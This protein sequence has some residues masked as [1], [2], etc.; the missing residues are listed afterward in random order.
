MNRYLL[1]YL[2]LLGVTLISCK[3]TYIGGYAATPKINIDYNLKVDLKIDTSKVLQATSTTSIYFKLIKIGDNNFSD[4]FGG[5]VGDREKSAAT[6]KAL[7][8]SG[9]DIIVNPKYIVTVKRGLFVKK[10]QATVAGYGAKIQ[11]K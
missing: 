8:G 1:I 3:S 5:N 4:A 9:F 2:V 10:I 7:N 6:F 11:L